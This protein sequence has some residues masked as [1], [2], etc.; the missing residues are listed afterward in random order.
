MANQ[1]SGHPR[2]SQPRRRPRRQ[3]TSSR[4]EFCLERILWFSC[5]Y[6]PQC[7]LPTERAGVGC[8]AAPMAH[9]SPGQGIEIFIFISFRPTGGHQGCSEETGRRRGLLPRNPARAQRRPH[10]VSTADGWCPDLAGGR[11]TTRKKA[12]ADSPRFP[13]RRLTALARWCSLGRRAAPVHRDMGSRHVV[14]AMIRQAVRGADR[15]SRF[16]NNLDR[17]A[18]DADGV[19]LVG[20]PAGRDG[21]R[22]QAPEGCC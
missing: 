11:R 5:S 14:P 16:V 1:A 17:R 15:L 2:G 4:F 21:G 19:N 3:G 13:K 10:V 12:N 9:Q 18:R 6:R 7:I 22:T 20:W 8:R